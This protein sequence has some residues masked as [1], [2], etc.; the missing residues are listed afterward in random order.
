MTPNQWN[1][2]YEKVYKL[3]LVALGV[4]LMLISW[5]LWK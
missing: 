4:L 1:V 2:C 3:G 5:C